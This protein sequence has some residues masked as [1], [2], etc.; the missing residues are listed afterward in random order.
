MKVF[1]VF[2]NLVGDLGGF[3]VG[4]VRGDLY[5]LFEEVCFW[6]VDFS[7]DMGFLS[8]KSVINNI[9]VCK[10][11]IVKKIIKFKRNMKE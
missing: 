6:F 4:W 9:K 8:L 1:K 3:D 2:E 10:M 7:W 11:D 5:W